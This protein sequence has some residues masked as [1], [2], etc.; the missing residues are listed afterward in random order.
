[1][2][3]LA[4]FNVEPR[5]KHAGVT[6]EDAGLTPSR[7][8]EDALDARC[9]LSRAIANRRSPILQMESVADRVTVSRPLR[10]TRPSGSPGGN[11]AG[12]CQPAYPLRSIARALSTVHAP[13]FH[14]C[15]SCVHWRFAL[16]EFRFTL[17]DGE[18]GERFDDVACKL[19][20]AALPWDPWKARIIRKMR[21]REDLAAKA[22]HSRSFCRPSMTILRHPQR[23]GP[24][25]RCRVRC[26]GTRRWRRSVVGVSR[27]DSSS[28]STCFSSIDT[29]MRIAT[30]L[31]RRIALPD[32]GVRVH[33]CCDVR[34]RRTRLRGSSGV[35]VIDTI[36]IRSGSTGHRLLVP[37]GTV[38]T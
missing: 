5:R 37:Y 2:I 16:V 21:L 12:S 8:D 30:V 13:H 22:T 24:Y 36:P 32:I 25:D 3:G 33:A 9:A 15:R 28:H 10:G 17:L 31:P 19:R 7:D 4:S 29:S 1:V 20:A 6:D 26:A 27:A 11:S 18:R 34:N 38:R 14:A 35:P 23:N